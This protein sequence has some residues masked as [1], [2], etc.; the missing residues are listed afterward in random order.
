[1]L[2]DW[3]D[4]AEIE[5]TRT[6]R[7]GRAGEGGVGAAATVPPDATAG[8][9]GR[10][11]RP[12]L[13]RAVW[14]ALLAAAAVAVMLDDIPEWLPE[15]MRTELPFRSERPLERRTPS[16]W[17]TATDHLFEK[18]GAR[19]DGASGR[20]VRDDTFCGDHVLPREA[21]QAAPFLGATED[22]GR[23]WRVTVHHSGGDVLT[24]DGLSGTARILRAIQ[25]DHQ[26]RRRW[27]DIG[28]HYIVDR[29]GR[30]W[31]GRPVRWVGAHAGSSGANEGNLGILVLG[32]FDEQSP[33]PAQIRAL[34]RLVESLRRL[35]GIPRAGVLT[36]AEV[37]AT[38]GMATTN[39]P[40][41]D[42]A[43]WLEKYRQDG[44]A[45][46][47]TGDHVGG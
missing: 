7:T 37:R 9:T 47:E 8:V 6:G 31:E 22:L 2:E 10:E 41:R 30:V 46:V 39:C 27:V 45:T 16:G 13:R 18:S 17:F 24:T 35:H 5:T 20:W 44:T 15:W 33:P 28:Y 40:G 25:R 32:N 38:H 14:F 11:A 29:A 21:W 3:V 4:Y 34:T 26:E 1:M 43:G 36:H 19:P 23:P 42:L 12:G